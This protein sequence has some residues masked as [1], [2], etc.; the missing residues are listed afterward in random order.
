MSTTANDAMTYRFQGSGIDVIVEKG[1]TSGKVAISVDGGP[2]QVVDLYEAPE[3]DY[4]TVYGARNLAPGVAHTIRVENLNGKEL[5]F[6]GLRVHMHPGQRHYDASLASLDVTGAK[7]Y[8]FDPRLTTYRLL[9]PEGT[10]TVSV[11]PTLTD[12]AGSLTIN[13]TSMANGATATVHVPDGKSTL[14]LRTT[15]SDG[16]TSSLY[17]VEL[18]KGALN[19]PDANVARSYSAITASATRS[20][21]GGVTYGPQ[22]MVDGD[23]G[24]MFAA[25]QGYTD[26]HPFPHEIALTWSEPQNLNTIV[27]QTPSGV[28]QGITDADVQT[29]PD[30]ITWT[31]V[32]RGVQ[33]RWTRDK[34]DGVMESIAADLP[35][36]SNVTHLRLHINDANY[37]TWSMYA[38]YELQFYNLTDHGEVAIG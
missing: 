36:L 10:D 26:T 25:Q 8:L 30:G 24:T 35:N 18:V 19:T 37:K 6:D 21:D 27:M 16:A 22:K 7:D 12:S 2:A 38:V 11:T 20:G 17:T 14:H 9:I 23:D 15:A 33:F 28:L 13:G 34:D 4:V 1:N 3:Y 32:A 31:T 5:R 29:S